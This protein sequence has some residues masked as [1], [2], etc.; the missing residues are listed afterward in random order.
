MEKLD[1]AGPP[2]DFLLLLE[3]L[4]HIPR[5]GWKMRGID[6]PESVSGHIFFMTVMAGLSD[7][8]AGRRSDMALV[9]DMAESLV[10]D[11]TPFQGVSKEEK[12]QREFLAMRY[13]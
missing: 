11:I 8:D 5:T 6:R 3:R 4:K 13:L 9:H 2:M 7:G 12:Y 10:G 1:C